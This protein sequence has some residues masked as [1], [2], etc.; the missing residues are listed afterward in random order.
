MS[1]SFD[2][3]TTLPPR[4][5]W[6]LAYDRAPITLGRSYAAVWRLEN[7]DETLFL[8]SEPIH[9]LSELPGEIS[10]LRWLATMGVPAPQV[11][12][13]F[14]ADGRSYLLMSALPG[15]DL[16]QLTSTPEVL[17][18]VLAT[19]LR[20]LHGL[21]PAVCPF[22]R[23][24]DIHLAVGAA[25]VEAGR[26][27]ES[28]FDT[29][30]EGWTAQAVLDWLL[31]N[32]PEGED[33]VVTHGDASLPNLT[34]HNGSFSGVLDCGRLGVTDRWQD[35]AIA[36][37]SLKYNC[38]PEHVA[39]FLAAYGAPWDEERYRYYGTLDELF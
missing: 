34:A 19:G 29:G 18:N 13:A 15:T 26:V 37:R 32:R 9:P 10:R 8:K 30:H 17:R 24:L 1:T 21:D 25:N 3:E 2:P 22:D 38:G 20:A 16:T 23:R 4:L 35:L 27:D 31:A 6:L 12:D 11:R 39:P 14:E 36:C 5:A 33:L 28:D 7:G